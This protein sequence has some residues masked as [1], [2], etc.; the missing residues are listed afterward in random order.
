MEI[1]EK[2]SIVNIKIHNC[3]FNDSLVL[4]TILYGSLFNLSETNF[5]TVEDIFYYKGIEILNNNWLNKFKYM[6]YFFKYDIKQISFN[7]SFVIFGYPIIEN[8]I[9]KLIQNL[10][11]LKYKIYSIQLINLNKINYSDK[12]LYKN[13]NI[14]LKNQTTINEEKREN[15]VNKKCKKD[16]IFEVRPDIQ[17][18]IYYLYCYDDIKLVNYGIALVPDI[19]TSKMLNNIFRNIKENTN[20]DLLEE[21]DSEEEFENEKIDKYVYLDKKVNMNCLY[22]YKFKKWYPT[23]LANEKDVITNIAELKNYKI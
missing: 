15:L 4:G 10:E 19:K 18:D 13:I 21:S 9:N 20:L 2:K 17:N 16:Y 7:K 8:N 5:F 14:L 22:N 1:S 3:V 12:I 11:K 23:K 6:E